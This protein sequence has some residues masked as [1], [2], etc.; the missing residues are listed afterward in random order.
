MYR[1]WDEFEVPHRR[2]E[3]VRLRA[4]REGVYWQS[5]D[6]LIVRMAAGE[7]A[8]DAVE[9]QRAFLELA[10]RDALGL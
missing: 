10:V 4:P 8:H 1:L 3:G 5:K 2:D 9:A 6:G 7:S